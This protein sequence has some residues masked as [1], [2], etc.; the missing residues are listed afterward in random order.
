M[1]AEKME[2]VTERSAAPRK[3]GVA[4][5]FGLPVPFPSLPSSKWSLDINK[6]IIDRFDGGTVLVGRCHTIGNLA[7]AS[8]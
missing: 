3:G 4:L 1:A 2:L 5:G 7:Q 6:R 8:L